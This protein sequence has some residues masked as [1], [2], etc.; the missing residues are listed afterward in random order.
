M[1]ADA[2]KLPLNMLSY[3][4]NMAADIE[5]ASQA[6]VSKT[7]ARLEGANLV[8]FS[9]DS[10]E[11]LSEHTAAMPVFVQVLEGELAITA[12]DQ[13]INLQ[14]GGIVHFATRLPHAL[15]ALKPTKMLL[16]MMSREK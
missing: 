5:F 10:G 16:I 12:Q 14:P 8:L 6:T 15:K 9:F 11:E 13:T 4:P 2:H 1:S 3:I 7:V